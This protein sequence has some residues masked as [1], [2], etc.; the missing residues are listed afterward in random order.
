MAGAL[1]AL[2]LSM[3]QSGTSV[4]ES[5]I[6]RDFPG[7]PVAKTLSFQCWGSGFNPWL[8]N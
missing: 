6:L 2:L 5:V 7:G 4:N 3:S 1:Q 8:G